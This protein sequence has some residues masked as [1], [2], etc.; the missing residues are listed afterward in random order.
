M[1][2]LVIRPFAEDDRLACQQIAADA[3]LSSY[4]AQMPEMAEA[5]L[6]ASPLEE[7]QVR[8][9]AVLNGEPAG[10]IDLNGDHVENLFVSPAAQ[11]RGVGS[12]LMAAAEDGASGDLTLSV[13]TSNPGARRLYERLGFTF[14]GERDTTFHGRAYPVWAMRKARRP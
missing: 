9:V 4:G 3:A 2:D 11:G 8:L 7:V 5:F 12:R 13:F 10:F 1:P 6:P 14:T